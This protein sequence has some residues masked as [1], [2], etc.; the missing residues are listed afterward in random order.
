M[1][2]SEVDFAILAPVPSVHLESGLSVVVEQGFVAFGSMKWQLFREAD[3]LRMDRPVPV[4]IYPSH[5]SKLAK[6]TF[7]VTWLGWYIG[8]VTSRGGAHP[9]GM[10]YRPES[11]TNN[12]SDNSGHWAIF[13]HVKGLREL[14]REQQLPI[15]SLESYKSGYWRKYYAPRG[16]EIV[17]R[18]C[19]IDFTV[20]G[21]R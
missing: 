9:D 12:P 5:E 1:L 13:W 16:P 6:L 18:P 2:T 7:N 20:R 21:P 17:A 3:K 19:G 15:S 8:H 10:K 11:T 4:L 14:P